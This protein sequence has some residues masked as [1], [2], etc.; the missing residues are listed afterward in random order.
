MMT[1]LRTEQDSRF[2]TLLESLY[3]QFAQSDI[4]HK[5]RARAWG[6][7]LDLGLPTKSNDVYRYLR[8]RNFFAADYEAAYVT[9]LSQ[10]AIDSHVLPECRQSV[11]VFVNGYYSAEL[12]NLSGISTR[13]VV[14]SLAEAMR[15]YGVF[16]NNQWA[17]VFKE[18][19]DAFA[20]INMALH[21]AGVFVYVPPKTIVEAPL[22]ILNLV[23]AQSSA[24]Y[25]MPRAQVF[26]GAQAQLALV[27]TTGVISGDKFG[28][29]LVTDF[30]IEEDAHVKFT[31]VSFGHSD[32]IWQFEAVRAGLKR[33]SSFTSVWMTDGASTIRQDYR[34]AL[35]GE[36]A[37]V[38]LNGVSMLKGK[39]ESH[40]HVLVDHQAPNCRSLQLFKNALEDFSHSSF[41]GKIL[42]R[43]AAQKT[44]AFQLNNNLLLSDRAHADSKPNLEIFADDVKASHGA[45]MGQLDAEQIF[46]MKTRGF[47]EASAKN[48]L[49]NGFCQEVIGLIPLPSI[50]ETMSRYAQNFMVE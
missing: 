14:S 13:V 4:L 18:E 7:F 27:S 24:M 40:V 46:Y 26:V 33:D 36:N 41:E 35:M 34:V 21:P 20:A 32:Q 42:V 25:I 1:E 48:I 29:N 15:T 3:G 23:D 47:S 11:M 2:Q 19:S 30:A 28:V 5:L 12:S 44:E 22:Q 17:K 9:D 10:E 6:R 39:K 8:L 38:N 37:E 31:Q 16:L 50:Q 49:V 45:T 43:Q